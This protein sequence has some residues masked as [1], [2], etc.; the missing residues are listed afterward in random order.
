MAPENVIWQ[1]AAD[2]SPEDLTLLYRCRQDGGWID[3]VRLSPDARVAV[4][5]RLLPAEMD[6][7]SSVVFFETERWSPLWAV[8]VPH[9][10]GNPDDTRIIF[11]TNDRY[12]MTN[13]GLAMYERDRVLWKAE[14]P[15][16]TFT[17]IG[18][19]HYDL[20][21]EPRSYGTPAADESF[22]YIRTRWSR[23]LEPGGGYDGWQW[24]D[25]DSVEV[26]SLQ[27]GSWVR[28]IEQSGSAR[29]EVPDRRFV[30][31][32]GTRA[33]VWNGKVTLGTLEAPGRS[34]QSADVVGDRAL[35]VLD[36]PELLFLKATR[37]LVGS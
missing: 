30:I 6:K 18:G 15:Q 31:T 22:L 7:S 26:I 4:I 10:Q 12:F 16:P 35:V 29:P 2:S 11:F 1:S 20:K 27:D 23:P 32:R 8:K 14:L 3:N 36:G 33:E 24:Q 17:L 21:W 13:H 37:T 28:R 19:W 25:E 9:Q 34:M 5:Q